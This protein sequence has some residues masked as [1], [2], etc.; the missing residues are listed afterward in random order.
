MIFRTT[1]DDANRQ[2]A[3]WLARLHADDRTSADEADFSRWVAAD[4]S[5][6]KAFER[7]SSIWD[8]L[9]GVSDL[10]GVPA[11]PLL[12]RRKVL[13]GGAAV[14]VAG[15]GGFALVPA[16]AAEYSTGVGEQRRITLEDGTRVM[17]DTATLIRFSSTR[18]RR[19]LALV[20]G[21][22]AVEIAVD[23]R[24]FVIAA[25]SRKATARDAR[26]DVRRDGEAL[27]VTALSGSVKLSQPGTERVLAT[28]ERLAITA[29]A[30]VSI[31]EPELRDLTAWQ[32]GRLA[33][34]DESMATAV[35]EMNRYSTR[36]LIIADPAAGR[37][38]LSGVYRV[39][40]PEAFARSLAV[41]HGVEVAVSPETVAISLPQ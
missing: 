23:P 15:A 35:A 41:L 28:G 36:Q 38:R 19:D 30:V 26:V 24:P 3:D 18:E 33:F 8:A 34:R 27:A 14:M 12:S 29:D 5:N 6:A 20:A 11:R 10:S 17:L 21:R 1:S 16:S 40:D 7:A 37:L 31:D 25:G 22:I 32:S 2:A 39:G 4:P 9:G 13:A